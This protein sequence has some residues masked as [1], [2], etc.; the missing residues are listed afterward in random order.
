MYQSRVA[1]IT[2]LPSTSTPVTEAK[3]CK[4]GRYNAGVTVK[5]RSD[6]PCS[7]KTD[8]ACFH[9]VDFV[10]QRAEALVGQ[11]A[12]VRHEQR[13][14][15]TAERLAE[16]IDELQRVLEQDNQLRRPKP[17]A[18]RGRG[19]RCETALVLRCP[20]QRAV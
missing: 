20:A 18:R 11:H 10:E 14:P 5:T 15:R 6:G 9:L 12:A 4:G 1:P 3:H 19:W 17:K 2:I 16:W 8:G 7:K 13:G